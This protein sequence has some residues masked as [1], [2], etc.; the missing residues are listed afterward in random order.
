MCKIIDGSYISSVKFCGANPLV[1]VGF[2]DGKVRVYDIEKL[3]LVREMNTHEK[4][5]SAL[6]FPSSTCVSV[7]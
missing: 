2:S 5:V 7:S 4:R 3:S 1:S 6:E